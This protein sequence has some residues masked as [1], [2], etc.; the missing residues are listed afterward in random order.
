MNPV[1]NEMTRKTG[2]IRPIKSDPQRLE[3]TAA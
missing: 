1:I 3:K 2:S